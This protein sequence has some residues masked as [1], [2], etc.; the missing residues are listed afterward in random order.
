MP[1]KRFIPYVQNQEMLLPPNLDEMVPA[2]H[3]V[4]TISSVIDAIDTSTLLDLYPGGGRSAYHPTMLLK[5]VTFAYASGIFSSRKIAQASKE[6]VY[7]LWLSG[8]TTLDHNTI[9]RFRSKRI[10]PLFEEI[11]TEVV[12][13]LSEHGYLDLDT[14]FLDG[15]KIEANANKY[16][17]VWKK[18]TARYSEALRKRIAEHLEQIDKL[19]EEEEALL[20]DKETEDI[21]SKDIEN[22]AEKINRRLKKAPKDKNLK[23]VARKIS[24]DYLPRLKKYESQAKTFGNNRGSYAKTDTDATFMR[25]KEDHMLNGQL[26]AGYNA[27]IGTNNQFVLAYSI[28]QD[29]SDSLTLPAHLAH[30]K[31]HFDTLPKK[32]CADAGYGS[33]E[34]YTLLEKDNVCAFVK[35]NMF[36]KEQKRTYRTKNK[37]YKAKDFIYDKASDSYLCPEGKSLHFDRVRTSKTAT[38]YL[39]S[40]RVYICTDCH[41]CPARSKC[42]QQSGKQR[43]LWVNEERIRLQNQAKE[44]LTSEEGLAL[45]KRRATDVETVFG[46]IKQNYGFRRF[47]MRGI[48]KVSLEWGWMMMGHNMRKLHAQMTK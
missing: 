10:A 4:R 26:K 31:S 25:M 36:H 34:N 41:T 17:F 44:L 32:I 39:T 33:E 37:S 19:N 47:S 7:F 27:Q 20:K 22:V 30:F 24:A 5:V 18:N 21:T 6:S 1:D 29:R 45:R 28:H 23:K 9:N 48:E 38:G 35:Y 15:T 11:F 42:I 46:N 16:S 14:Y 3:M 40:S 8:Q 13:L 2:D 12:M 43:Q